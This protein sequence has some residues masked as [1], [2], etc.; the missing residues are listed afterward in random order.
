MTTE[1]I[2]ADQSIGKGST[3]GNER[4]LLPANDAAYQRSSE[5]VAILL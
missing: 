2:I 3:A 4:F 5:N 1:Q